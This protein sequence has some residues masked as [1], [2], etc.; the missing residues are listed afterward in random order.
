MLTYVCI[1]PM[2]MQ[3]QPVLRIYFAASSLEVFCPYMDYSYFLNLQSDPYIV[4]I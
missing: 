3:L 4:Y 1:Y 2:Y